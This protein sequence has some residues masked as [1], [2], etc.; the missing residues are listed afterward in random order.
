[1]RVDWAIPCRYAETAEDGT[2]TL[3]G[4][5]IDSMWAASL[6]HRA[7]VVL[8]LRFVGPEDEFEEGAAWRFAS[9]TRDRARRP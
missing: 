7:A 2:A 8:M 9:S 4:A 1:L 5:G 3:V 6:P